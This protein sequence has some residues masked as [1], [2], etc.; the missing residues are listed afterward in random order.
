MAYPLARM[1]GHRLGRALATVPCP[2][3][4]RPQLSRQR[5]AAGK[6][7]S[8]AC[9]EL[10]RQKESALRVA[11]EKETLMKEKAGLMVQVAA[12]ERENHCLLEELAGLR[13]VPGRLSGRWSQKERRCARNP[14]VA[15]QLLRSG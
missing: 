3:S 6:E 14:L 12:L 15:W 11:Q 2:F 13:W 1:G 4:L 5:N 7:L 9:Q 10:E 8:Q